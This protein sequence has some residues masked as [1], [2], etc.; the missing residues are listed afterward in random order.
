MAETETER[1]RH[2]RTEV[3]L[4]VTVEKIGGRAIS[5]AGSTIDISEGGARLVGPAALVVGD[6]VRVT[7]T[8]S[9]VS[10]EQQGLV[11]GRQEAAR[12]QATLNI[13]FKTLDDQRTIDLRR[14]IDRT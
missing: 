13:A 3:E 5:G 7:L 9:D 12:G 6:V 11:V 10:V 8:G 1:R 4:S 14:L 2:P